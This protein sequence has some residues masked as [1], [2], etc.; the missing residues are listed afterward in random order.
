M[1][2]CPGSAGAFAST[3]SS[4]SPP[5]PFLYPYQ[6]LDSHL[7][8]S[9]GSAA[10]VAGWGRRGRGQSSANTLTLS[11]GASAHVVSPALCTPAYITTA[12][13]VEKSCCSSFA[14]GVPGPVSSCGPPPRCWCV[15]RSLTMPCRPLLSSSEICRGL[16]PLRACW[17]ATLDVV[18]PLSISAS[19]PFGWLRATNV[20]RATLESR[21]CSCIRVTG[22]WIPASTSQAW[23]SFFCH[24]HRLHSTVTALQTGRCAQP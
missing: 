20:S 15:P 19:S 5:L 22:R 18:E 2:L 8:L 3:S 6:L 24:M 16:S 10:D 14:P 4:P 23:K 9:R 13:C 21:D 1:H 11:F 7:A 12:S 17:R